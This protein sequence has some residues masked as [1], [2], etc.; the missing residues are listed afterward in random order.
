[1]LD[2][3]YN[4]EITIR[5]AAGRDGRNQITYQ[6]VVD[7]TGGALRIR[8]RVTHRARRIYAL[9]G[10]QKEIDAEMVYR[11][12]AY[13]N[14][15]DEDLIVRADGEVLRVESVNRETMIGTGINYARAF[16]RVTKMP[17]PADPH[18]N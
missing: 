18:G 14:L 7:G 8:C 6:Q 4:E 1:M 5:R 9:D 16:L 3:F 17:V 15:K 10:T 11:D 13:P 2:I 12:G